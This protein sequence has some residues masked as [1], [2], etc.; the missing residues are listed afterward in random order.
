MS[1]S[2][3]QAREDFQQRLDAAVDGQSITLGPGELP[4]PV[5]VRTA[6]TLVGQGTTLWALQGPLVSV[7]SSGVVLR[8]LRIEVT[9]ADDG[10]DPQQNCALLVEPGGGVRL[11]NVEVRGL[12]IGLDEEEG[13]WRYPTALHLGQLS[14]DTEQHFLLRL[15]IPVRCELSSNIA[16]LEVKPKRLDAGRHE[17]TLQVEGLLPDTLL[18]GTICLASKFLKR[19]IMVSAHV[20]EALA[21]AVASPPTAAIVWQPP[22]WDSLDNAGLPGPPLVVAADGSGQYRTLADA[23]QNAPVGAQI[24]VRRGVYREGII[25][26]RRLEISGDGPAADIII[27]CANASC[28]RLQ[29]EQGKLRGLTFRGVAGSSGGSGYP[30]VDLA[31]GRVVMEDCIITSDSLACVAIH[32]PSASPVLRRCTIHGG[33][34]VGV[35]L[36]DRAGALLEN[37]NIHGN[38]LAGVEIREDAAPRLRGCRI[39]DGQETGVLVHDNGRGDLEDCNISRNA[40]AGV[41]ICRGGNPVLRRCAVHDGRYTG[42][43]IG[44]NGLGTLEDCDI[45]GNTLAGVEIKRGGNPVIR[46]SRIHHGKQAGVFFLGQGLGMLIEC[47]IFNNALSGVEIKEESDP[48]LRQCKIHDNRL[49][50]VLIGDRGKGTLEDCVIR[51]NPLSGVAIMLN[52]NPMLRRCKISHSKQY[53]LNVDEDG[54]GTLE[55][56]EIFETLWSAVSIGRGGNPTLRKC[57][58]HDSRQAGLLVRQWR[59]HSRGVRDLR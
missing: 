36:Y 40:L 42:V 32:G 13:E 38:A 29:T 58:F 11:E 39:H 4:G 16:G 59:G 55:E 27:E 50:G 7:E 2:N 37:C 12:V 52:G 19:S 14:P 56:C 33:K 31:G 8:N 44:E 34:S 22:D 46:K 17:L 51:D 3:E 53:G 20:G 54:R 10:G 6:V 25:L 49:A 26:D 23:I 48:A 43:S 57:R 15:V 47:D 35:V 18:T 5:I 21:G 45:S 41:E 9:G 28:L 1:K 24:Q 30:A